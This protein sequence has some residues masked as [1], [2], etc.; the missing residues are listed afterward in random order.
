MA[1]STEEGLKPLLGYHVAQDLRI[2]GG[3][4]DHT[5]S[6]SCDLSSPAFVKFPLWARAMWP[7]TYFVTRGCAFSL[8]AVPVV[9]YPNMAYR[10]F[11]AV[12]MIQDSGVKR[13]RYQ[14]QI[15][16]T[17]YDSAVV[18]RNSAAFLSPVLEGVEPHVGLVHHVYVLVPWRTPRRLRTPRSACQT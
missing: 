11:S 2:V 4:K 6:S 5:L 16:V 3:L 9:E 7:L 10:N 18:D 15:L 14:P 8:F 1:S 12:Q 17:Q 13:L